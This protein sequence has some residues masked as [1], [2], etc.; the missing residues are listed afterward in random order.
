MYTRPDLLHLISC[1]D[2]TSL[3]ATDHEQSILKLVQKANTGFNDVYPAAI[4][5]YPNFGNLVVK[6]ALP[7]I[8]T[9]VVGGYFP[10]GQTYTAAKI[11]ELSEIEKSLV[12]EVDIVI[13]RGEFLNENYTYVADEIRQMRKAVPTKK[14]KVILETGELKST[15][16]IQ[17]ASE[18][19]IE[20]GADFIK[21][22]TGKSAVGA[23]PEAIEIMCSVIRNHFEK[24]GKKIGIKPSGGIRQI[25][26][27]FQ[28]VNIV[29]THLGDE[30]LTQQLFRIG[31]SSLYDA[32]ITQLSHGD[33]Q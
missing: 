30:W 26:E 18:I 7:T 31:A 2:L 6:S 8:S 25:D 27:A 24:T 5:V 21:T 22:S 9:A 28:Y 23:T 20:A 33:K 29:R 4:C 13:N 17:K 11:A 10:S 16:L 12:H 19:A 32:I 15:A 1:I 3:E 14:L